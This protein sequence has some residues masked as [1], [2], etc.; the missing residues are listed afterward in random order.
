MTH[1]QFIMIVVS[2]TILAAGVAFSAET[3]PTTADAQT[4]SKSDTSHKPKARTV[5]K[6][7]VKPARAVV[8]NSTKAAGKHSA[9]GKAPAKPAQGTG[10]AS[11]P[12]HTNTMNH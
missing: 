3:K 6:A 11:T 7:S 10:T 2:S 4:T 9:A 1:R 5:T 8:K 12:E